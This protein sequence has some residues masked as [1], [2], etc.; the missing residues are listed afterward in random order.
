MAKYRVLTKSFINNTIVE[1]GDVVEYDGKAGTNLELV[2]GDKPEAKA[3]G[4]GKGAAPA[5]SDAGDAGADL[6]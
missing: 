3:K 4:K 1:A 5:A 2:E 6:V